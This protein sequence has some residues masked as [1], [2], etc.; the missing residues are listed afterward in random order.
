MQKWFDTQ[1]QSLIDLIDSP[2]QNNVGHFANQVFFA[3]GGI[4]GTYDSNTDPKTDSNTG[5]KTEAN[6][7]SLTQRLTSAADKTFNVSSDPNTNQG[8]YGESPLG[9]GF[10]N[11]SPYIAS[12]Y[13]QLGKFFTGAGA[14]NE[15]T[16][17][18]DQPTKQPAAKSEN[19]G[20]FYARWYE[21]MRRFAEAEEVANHGQ[22]I[23]RSK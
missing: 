1:Q 18:F 22:T 4:A 12:H 15:Y 20:D 8:K 11:S 17:R 23:A 6:E 19:P 7:I 14:G 9:Q 5:L 10:Y 21:G 13:T 2:A 16:N 3:G